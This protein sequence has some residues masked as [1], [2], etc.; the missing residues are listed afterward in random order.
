LYLLSLKKKVAS[1]Y[2]SQLFD[3]LFFFDFFWG[4]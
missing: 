1:I 4:F 3:F 2:T